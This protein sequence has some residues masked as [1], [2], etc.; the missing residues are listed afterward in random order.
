M[1]APP[2][3]PLRCSERPSHQ[4]HARPAA[5]ETE[6]QHETNL[7]QDLFIR[8]TAVKTWVYGLRWFKFKCIDMSQLASTSLLVP[9]FLLWQN[10]G[11]RPTSP[12]T[13]IGVPDLHN[14]PTFGNFGSWQNR[15]ERPPQIWTG[16]TGSRH[17]AVKTVTHGAACY[18]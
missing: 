14:T 17:T 18:S 5:S 11:F 15:K 9:F 2:F 7:G 8:C 3:G 13:F 12:V 6:D 1:S 16:N 4:F 10:Q